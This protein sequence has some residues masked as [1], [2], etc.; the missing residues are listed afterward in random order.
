VRKKKG[1]K[2]VKTDRVDPNKNPKM[3]KKRTVPTPGSVLK[4]RLSKRERDKKKREDLWR[5]SHGKKPYPSNT[6]KVH[7]KR[8]E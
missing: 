5:L 4:Q 1:G 2:H 3:L 7:L 6:L 8:P